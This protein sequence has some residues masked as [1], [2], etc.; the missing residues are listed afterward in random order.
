MTS[1]VNAITHRAFGTLS[2]ALFLVTLTAPALADGPTTSVKTDYL[3]TVQ[4]SLSA[5]LAV[6]QSL[7]VYPHP[8]GT[9]Q[10]PKIK[11]KLVSP[12][13]DWGRIMPS[14]I[15]RIDVRDMIQTDD[16][17]LIYMA[18]NGAIQCSK[19]QMD[20]LNKGELLKADDCYFIMAPTFETKS[21]K[22]G[23]LNA[24]QAVGK[25]VEV[26]T[27]EGSYVKYDVFALK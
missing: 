26:K 2:R 8:G 1:I 3:M 11:G 10:G 27:G 20:R 16:G 19:E 7:I 13:A 6:D 5:P 23:W 14:G 24:T 25:M 22:Y 18:V 9:V 21:E 4:A 12:G 15:F 17:E